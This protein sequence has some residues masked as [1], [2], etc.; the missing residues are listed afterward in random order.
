MSSTHAL[1]NP[2]MQELERVH[3]TLRRDLRA[4]LDLADAVLTDTPAADVRGAV[5]QLSTRSPHLRL[6]VDCLRYCTLVHSH[7][8]GEDDSLF[9]AV[10]RSAPHLGDVI[11]GLEADH[12]V[13]SNLLDDVEEA[14]NQLG[15]PNAPIAESHLVTAL[16]A[17]SRHLLVHL[18]VEERVLRP[19]LLSWQQWPADE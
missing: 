19:V 10:R 6:G 15:G 13:V 4:C 1:T 3:A 9:P 14:A 8:G 11:D 17:L 16:A 12:H 2:L 5:R 7:H 18:D